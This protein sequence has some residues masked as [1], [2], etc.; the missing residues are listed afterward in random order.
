M[1]EIVFIVPVL[2]TLRMGTDSRASGVKKQTNP[3]QLQS[4]ACNLRLCGITGIKQTSSY[5][6]DGWFQILMLSHQVSSFHHL[7]A[8]V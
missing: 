4:L 1:H 3:Q 2:E 8:G 5:T 6:L 7:K